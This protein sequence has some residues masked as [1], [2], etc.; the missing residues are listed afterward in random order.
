[1]GRKKTPKVVKFGKEVIK[2]TGKGL[3]R[4]AADTVSG[5]F[6]EL[7]SILTLQKAPKR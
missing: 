1:M 5:V 7:G 4:L 2:G 3:G 6:S